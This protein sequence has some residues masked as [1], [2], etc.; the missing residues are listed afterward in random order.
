MATLN[1]VET[2]LIKNRKHIFLLT[3]G[4][5]CMHCCWHTMIRVR[6]SGMQFLIID[7]LGLF[8]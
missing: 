7:M 5:I 2:T 3:I 4:Y 8:V 1:R 6:D